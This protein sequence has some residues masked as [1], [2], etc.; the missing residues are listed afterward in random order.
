MYNTAAILYTIIAHEIK[1]TDKNLR[2][3]NA[4]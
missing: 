4:G 3:L 1:S 2:D